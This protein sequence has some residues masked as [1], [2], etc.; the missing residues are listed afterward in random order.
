MY[1]FGITGPTGAGKSTVSEYFREL[2]VRVADADK[3]ARAVTEK[4][5]RCLIELADAFG[6]EILLEDGTLDRR[7][8]GDMVFSDENKLS[9]LNGI[10][11]KYIKERIERELSESGARICAV[12]GAVIIGSPA[13]ELC[14][15]LV[16]VTAE[17]K[18]RLRR[19]M[20][21]DNISEQS[22]RLRMN[23]QPAEEEYLH[24]ADYVIEN[25]G[26]ENLGEQIEQIYH[27]IESDAEKEAS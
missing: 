6:H 10:T 20:R 8:L 9:L 12:D 16:V 1:I 4:G 23:A 2:G 15:R 17:P 24:F 27:E 21:R 25:N 11:H 13:A 19:V 5:E 14:R 18:T 22:A 3:A 7:R 26:S